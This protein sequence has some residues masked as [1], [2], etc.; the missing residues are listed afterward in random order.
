VFTRNLFIVTQDKLILG[1]ANM[2]ADLADD[3]E[4]DHKDIKGGGAFQQKDKSHFILFGESHQ[5]G[6]FNVATTNNHIKNG[7]HSW[8]LH[9]YPDFTFEFDLERE[10]TEADRF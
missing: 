5:F 6:R 8:F 10:E 9:T 7:T 1:R 4:I 3:C 2:H